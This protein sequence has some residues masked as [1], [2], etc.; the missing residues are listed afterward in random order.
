MRLNFASRLTVFRLQRTIQSA[1]REHSS[2]PCTALCSWWSMAF[3]QSLP[4]LGPG[5][6]MMS[7]RLW[8][9]SSPCSRRRDTRGPG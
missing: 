1:E 8:G 5:R 2:G 9:N 3:C 7:S 6:T 4:R